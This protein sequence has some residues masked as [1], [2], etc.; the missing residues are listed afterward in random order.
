[1]ETAS[2][3]YA[4]WDLKSLKK[5]VENLFGVE[6]RSIAE[7]SIKSFCLRQD[8]ARY[9]FTEAMQRMKA[10][11]KD[12]ETGLCMQ[13]LTGDNEYLRNEFEAGA[14]TMACIQSI[15][16]LSDILSTAIYYSMGLNLDPRTSINPKR[17]YLSVLNQKLTQIISASK[18]AALI[19]QIL[20]HQDYEYVANVVNESK[21]SSVIAARVTMDFT[22]NENELRFEAFFRDGV[23]IPPRGVAGVLQ[24]EFTRQSL[25][26]ISVGNEV[27]AW[28]SAQRSS[29]GN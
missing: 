7:K 27:N 2:V 9:H 1:M 14:H 8:Y 19:S 18:I 25:L 11:M 6:Q 10:I 23:R 17:L 5:D 12:G 4:Q 3:P 15:H 22:T 21:H 24:K 26:M 29:S 16:S 20:K 13:M 28:V